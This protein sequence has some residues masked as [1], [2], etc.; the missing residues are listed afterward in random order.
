M[1]Q[2]E[3]CGSILQRCSSSCC[4]WKIQ[5]ETNELAHFF[6]IIAPCHSTCHGIHID[7]G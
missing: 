6:H 2:L 3:V 5:S 4:A 7:L 1:L